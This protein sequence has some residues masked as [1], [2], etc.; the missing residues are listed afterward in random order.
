M[1]RTQNIA[2]SATISELRVQR[3]SILQLRTQQGV[4]SAMVE[5]PSPRSTDARVRLRRKAWT[6]AELQRL[7]R[8]LTR[9]AEKL[10]G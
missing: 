10:D 4:V 8:V 2:L 6:A 5:I 9:A 1:A 7:V 3:R